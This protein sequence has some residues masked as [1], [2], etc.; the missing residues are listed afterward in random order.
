MKICH[1]LFDDTLQYALTINSHNS[2]K[3]QK[4][5]KEDSRKKQQEQDPDK[6]YSGTYWTTA[7]FY[8]N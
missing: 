6:L 4:D 2:C 8:S 1:T 3:K 7:S 5:N